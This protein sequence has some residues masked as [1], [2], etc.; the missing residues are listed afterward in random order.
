MDDT[1]RRLDHRPVP[2]P[3]FGPA[4]PAP[5]AMVEVEPGIFWLR[6]PLPF[7]LDHVNLWLL[8]DGDGWTVVDTGYGNRT[9]KEIWQ[10]LLDGPLAG[11][12][13]RRIVV[14]HFHPDH[15]G[16]AGWL[17]GLTG[18]AFWMPETEWLLARLLYVDAPDAAL[19]QA[20]AF[21]RLAGLEADTLA[22][23]RA[24]GHVYP[25]RITPPPLT[26]EPLRS[27]DEL[28]MGGRDWR[29]WTGV[30]HAP[31]EACFVAA[32]DGLFLSADHVLPR[33]SPNV[34]VWPQSPHA[35]PLG[36]FLRSLDDLRALPESI[37]ALPAHDWPFLDLHG[38]LRALAHHHHERLAATLAAVA[39][40]ATAADVFRHL[41]PH[42][43]D[44]HQLR[45][46]LG[47]TLAHLN[48]LVATGDVARWL[49][50]GVWRFARTR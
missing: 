2:A 23:M 30:G 39:A 37:R 18:A 50:G 14:T 19:E 48:R 10:G 4:T 20:L 43:H 41:F 42:I 21:Y 28:R 45:F 44:L 27:G 29:V 47:E 13:L 26:F 36:P 8:D 22:R 35:D 5:G 31:A 46:A 3:R 40:E 32:A 33:I 9:C 6:F 15:V 16:L 25:R 49:D 12:P 1:R 38:R 17:Q 24:D 34:A 11:R 7:A